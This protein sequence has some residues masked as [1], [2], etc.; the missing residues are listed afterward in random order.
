MNRYKTFFLTFLSTIV[1]NV[2][3]ADQQIPKIGIFVP[4]SGESSATWG[5]PVKKAIL[6]A[7]E[8]R[9]ISGAKLIFED[10][11][12]QNRI[13]ISGAHK[14]VDFEKVQMIIGDICW[15]DL[16]AKVTEPARV[17]VIAPGSAQSS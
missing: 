10:S 1:C 5:D 17:V 13:A 12:C 9:P 3:L 4:L 7:Q 2:V 16:I 15:T 11:Q 14:L 6:F 8:K